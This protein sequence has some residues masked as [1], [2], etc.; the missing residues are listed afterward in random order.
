M[1]RMRK[2]LKT[3]RVN[4]SNDRTIHGQGTISLSFLCTAVPVLTSVLVSTH[5]RLTLLHIP[6]GKDCAFPSGV[7]LSYTNTFVP[8]RTKHMLVKITPSVLSMLSDP[9]SSILFVIRPQRIVQF[10]LRKHTAREVRWQFAPLI[11]LIVG[12]PLGTFQIHI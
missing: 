11:R 12:K 8:L 3:S 2:T 9:L 1:I 5:H 10:I 7:I 4:W 6:T